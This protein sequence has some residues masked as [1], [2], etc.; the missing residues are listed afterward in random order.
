MQVFMAAAGKYMIGVV[1]CSLITEQ[2]APLVMVWRK[3]QPT[4][5]NILKNSLKSLRKLDLKLVKSSS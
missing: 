4:A 2:T 5:A 3:K 1:D